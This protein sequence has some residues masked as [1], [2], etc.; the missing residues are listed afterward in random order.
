MNRRLNA[1]GLLPRA[2]KFVVAVALLSIIGCSPD[3]IP[4]VSTGPLDDLE[5]IPQD[6]TAFAEPGGSPILQVDERRL[7]EFEDYWYG[8]WER[9]EPEICTAEE[10]GWAAESFPKQSIFGPNLLEVTASGLEA[11][12]ANAQLGKY[13]SRSAYGI[14]VRNTSMRALPSTDPFFYDFRKAGEGYPFDY[15][16]NSAVWAGTPLFLS[17]ISRDGRF[18]AAES[19]YTCGWIDSGDIAYVDE[20]FVAKYRSANL[21]AIRRDRI[22][23]SSNEGSFLFLG[24]IG[25][26]LPMAARA[27]SEVSL[28]APVADVRRRALLT[29]FS[30]LDRDA[31]LFP[32]PFSEDQLARLIN[33]ILGQPYGWGGLGGHRDCSSTI[34]DVFL[35]FALPLPRNS[36]KQAGAGRNVIIEKL[37]LAEK[38]ERIVSTAVP[39][40]TILNLSG[41]NMLYLG[42][43]EGSPVAFHTIWG[44]RTESTDESQSGRYL[45][46]KSVITSLSPGR[47]IS[48]LSRSRGDL[49]SRI[50]S[51]TL[52]GEQ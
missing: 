42:T 19:P 13:P 46:G 30:L 50:S 38:Q 41:H 5:K 39:F 12:T 36:R 25:M 27:E 51:F 21:A 33:E 23:I 2:D 43:F 47:E 28:L 48:S 6:A 32:L 3:E 26:I 15:N 17:H 35:P 10:F 40:R 45:I 37:S 24:R 20:E 1:G 8:P 52:L 18:I 34:L 22:P 4:L 9:T 49:L 31:A 7:G 29:R 16:Q 44:L 14:T 11:V